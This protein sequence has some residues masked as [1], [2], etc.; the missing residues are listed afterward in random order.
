MN[1]GRVFFIVDDIGQVVKVN[2]IGKDNGMYAFRERR[3]NRIFHLPN[4]DFVFDNRRDAMI[5]SLGGF[6]EI[7]YVDEHGELQDAE[8]GGFLIGNDANGRKVLFVVIPAEKG[9]L[10]DV[11]G[12]PK[13]VIASSSIRLDDYEANWIKETATARLHHYHSNFHS[14][15]NDQPT[16][17]CMLMQFEPAYYRRYSKTRFTFKKAK[18]ARKFLM[19]MN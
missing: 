3:G 15:E 10:N 17:V 4:V 11:L 2:F 1:R 8:T 9:S 6:H 7:K 12:E 19:N 13:A 18:V 5:F 14:L 16:P